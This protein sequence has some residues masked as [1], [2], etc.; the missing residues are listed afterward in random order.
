MSGSIGQGV[1]MAGNDEL[2]GLAGEINAMLDALEQ[3]RREVYASEARLRNI[4][5][6]MQDMITQTDALG[7]IQYASPSYETILGDKPEDWLGKSVLRIC[8]S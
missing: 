6:N 5:D 8:S 7:I 4:T 1:A 3:S 2:A